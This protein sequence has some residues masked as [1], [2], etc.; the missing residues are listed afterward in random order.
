MRNAGRQVS[1][2]MIIEHV[3]NL[4]FDTTTNVVDVYINLN[5]AVPVSVSHALLR[6]I[7]ADWN[8]RR[9]RRRGEWRERLKQ[10]LLEC[11]FPVELRAL[12][13]RAGIDQ[14]SDLS[15]GEILR[16]GGRANQPASLLVAGIE[17]FRALPARSGDMRVAQVLTASPD[18]QTSTSETSK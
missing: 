18:L 3:W 17:M 5:L 14:L 11:P 2:A 6:K 8:A 13:L 15:P 1:R 9:P 7:S 4:T 10:R 16:L 12:G